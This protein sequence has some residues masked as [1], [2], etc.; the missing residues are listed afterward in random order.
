MKCRNIKEGF[1]T[2]YQD[3]I[4]DLLKLEVIQKCPNYGIKTTNTTENFLFSY[5]KT[6]LNQ[7]FIK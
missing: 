3:T 7:L 6:R 2:K 4:N 5:H 1:L